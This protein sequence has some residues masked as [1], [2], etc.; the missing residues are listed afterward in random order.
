MH[1]MPCTV[2]CQEIW[3]GICE[4]SDRIS[5]WYNQPRGMTALEEPSNIATRPSP[6]RPWEFFFMFLF[7]W[8]VSSNSSAWPIHILNALSIPFSWSAIVTL[9]GWPKYSVHLRQFLKQ[10]AM[11]QY[12]SFQRGA[13][14]RGWQLVVHVVRKQLVESSIWL[15]PDSLTM[16]VVIGAFYSP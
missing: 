11:Y 4:S 1:S 9:P 8:C 5:A 10:Y 14:K 3:K 2:P 16:R 7:T 12:F 13:Q 6:S 15:W